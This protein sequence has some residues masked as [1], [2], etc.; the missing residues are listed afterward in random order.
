MRECVCET[1]T[2]TQRERERK[3]TV[4]YIYIYLYR[5]ILLLKGGGY[6]ERGGTDA[7]SR[8]TE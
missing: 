8:D 6:D 4:I 3:S 7:C 5:C 2:H 1:E